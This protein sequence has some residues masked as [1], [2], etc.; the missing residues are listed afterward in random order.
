MARLIFDQ[1]VQAAN[2]LVDSVAAAEWPNEALGC[3]EP[4]VFYATAGAP[5]SGVVYVLSAGSNSWDYHVSRDDS[6]FIRCTPI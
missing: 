3:P 1:G 6:V 2:L 4:G 5:Y